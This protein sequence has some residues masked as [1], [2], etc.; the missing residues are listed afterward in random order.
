M[1][2]KKII[3]V[4]VADDHPLMRDALCAAIEDEAD[5]QV[6]A[7]AMNGIEA[8]AKTLALKPDVTVMDLLMPGK[9]GIQAI[10]EIREANPEARILALTSSSED[11]M[12]LAAIHAGALGYMLKDS[13]PLDVLQAIR[14]VGLGN[15]VLPPAI[16]LKLANGVRRER[17]SAPPPPPVEPLTA[18]EL[19]VLKLI[20]Q[21]VSNREIATMLFLTEGTVRTH[22]HNILGKL[23]LKSRNQ[24]I[25]YAVRQGLAKES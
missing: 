18:R 22:V 14:D 2:E 9:T 6:I 16:A 21:G 20:G 1:S 19:E 7:T 15:S 23:D 8:V 25:L 17:S 5:L 11:D 24:A 4:L 10:A 13:Q 3:R 12:V